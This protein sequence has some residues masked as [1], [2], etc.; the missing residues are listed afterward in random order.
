MKGRLQVQAVVFVTV[1]VFA[2][3]MLAT[4]DNPNPAWL[5]FYSYAV[6]AAV[7]LVTAWDRWLWRLV[8]S[9]KVAAVPRN[10]NGTW[11][12]VLTTFWVDPET[13]V[14]PPPKPAFLVVRQTATTVSATMITDQMRSVSSL[15]SLSGVDGQRSLEYMYLSRPDSRYEM[16]SRIH[17]GSTSLDVTGIP[18][19]R[20]R[21]RY[22][23][24]R[25]SR[26]ELDFT[27]RRG[28][29]ADTYDTALRMFGD[30][31]SSQ[32]PAGDPPGTEGEGGR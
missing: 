8:I 13:G 6:T 28:G 27:E 20:L 18:P 19:D 24:N 16:H 14:V 21:G 7:A 17:H 29:F 15:A 30:A 2:V 11:K 32:D 25:D 12:G 26:G 1:L 9:Q 22:W 3:G 10:L 23:T 5:K 31:A 4:G